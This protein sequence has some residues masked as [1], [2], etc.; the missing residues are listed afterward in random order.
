[1]T[2]ARDNKGK[3]DLPAAASKAGKQCMVEIKN[4]KVMFRQKPMSL[5]KTTETMQETVK[6][7]EWLEERVEKQ[8]PP[9]SE[10]PRDHRPLV[11]KFVQESDKTISALCKHIQQELV[12]VD[13]EDDETPDPASRVLPLGTIE[14]AIVSVA[15][16][17]NYG[18]DV[19]NATKIPASLCVWRWEVRQEHYDWLPKASREKIEA[20]LVERAQAKKDLQALFDAL[21]QSEQDTM[22]GTKT[23]IKSK[24]QPLL[25]AMSNDATS[26]RDITPPV[27]AQETKADASEPE[28][29]GTPRGSGR[30]KKILDPEK[31][32][33]EKERLEKK[34]AKAE[35]EKKEK[36]AQTKARSMMASFFG[37]PKASNSASTSPAKGPAVASSSTAVSD[38]DKIFKPFVLKKDAELA[39]IN[40][41]HVS[42]RRRLVNDAEVIDLDPDEDVNDIDNDVEMIESNASDM[43]PKSRLRSIISSAPASFRVTPRRRSK[44]SASKRHTP[45]HDS[46]RSVMAQLAEAEISDDVGAV[47]TLLSRLRDRTQFPAKVLIFHEDERPGYFG[48]FTRHTRIIGPRRPWARDVVAL[49]YGYDS[50]EEWGGE[51]EGGGDDVADVS[52]DDR[53]EEADSSDLDGWLVDG[54]EKEV[55][56][57]I[58][59]REGLD[60][61]PF[62]PLP[63][64][65]KGKR[66]A[67]VGE[68]K[69][70][71]GAKA[72]KRKVVVPLVPFIKGPLWEREVGKCEYDPFKQYRIQFFNDSPYPL[73]PF[74]FVSTSTSEVP[75]STPQQPAVPT[76]IPLGKLTPHFVVPALPLHIINS[77]NSQTPAQP[78]PLPTV[79]RPPPAP[80]TAFPEA[81][82]PYL[83]QKVTYMGAR[84]LT[85]LV[86][87][88]Y[89]DLRTHKVKKNAV[90]AKI[91]EVCEKDQYQRWV[92]KDDK[93]KVADVPTPTTAG[94]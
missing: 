5:E 58:D 22:V 32:A 37:K 56:T 73:D 39:P 67:D 13:D 29:D 74:T 79:K 18:I 72:K 27:K 83:L 82:L 19:I 57:P 91:R 85:A 81:Y 31:A 93:S 65:S 12:P 66:K 60:A 90:E 15:R 35:K 62:P 30:P 77:T 45:I 9:L 50:G 71:D 55:A 88:I 41:F 47:R 17:V 1:M 20:R 43:S 92:V 3:V 51:E 86:E 28:N 87:A 61:F 14:E 25:R 23:V 75:K 49:D 70:G 59:E 8:E 36:D 10:I 54:D 44:T 7:R 34:S 64:P 94:A 53:D 46:V 38:F 11:A 68:E 48:T 2:D 40:W 69:G 6:F 76:S 78:P 52:D 84:S 80:K 33:K 42:K 4:G 21:P 89:Q 24:A 26:G 16:R 63:E